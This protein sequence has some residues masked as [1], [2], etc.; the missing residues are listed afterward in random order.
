MENVKF[1][2]NIEDD[3]NF[4][5]WYL[6][7]GYFYLYSSIN[8]SSSVFQNVGWENAMSGYTDLEV[9]DEQVLSSIIRE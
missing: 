8:Y 6:F 7:A 5:F 9:T 1:Y 4:Q 3:R 2:L